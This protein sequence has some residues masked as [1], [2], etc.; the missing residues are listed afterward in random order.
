MTTPL[1]EQKIIRKDGKEID[2]EVSGTLCKYENKKAIQIIA[3]DITEL[4][5]LIENL[6][7]S[8]NE[9]EKANKAKD[10]FLSVMSHELRTPLKRYTWFDSNSTIK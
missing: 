9:A 10:E 2:I 4:K 7:T 6:E 3:R 8:K 5:M 1:Y